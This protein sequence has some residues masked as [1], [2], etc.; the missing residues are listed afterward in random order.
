MTWEMVDGIKNVIISVIHNVNLCLGLGHHCSGLL[1]F[2]L[3]L[4]RENR[5]TVTDVYGTV[6][7]NIIYWY[8]SNLQE[9]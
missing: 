3:G 5:G 2:I 6:C 4:P 1:S 7:C 9:I 8:Y